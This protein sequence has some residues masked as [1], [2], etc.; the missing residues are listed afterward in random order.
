MKVAYSLV[1]YD[2]R[3]DF[4]VRFHTLADSVVPTAMEI[5]ALSP[6]MAAFYRDWPLTD[7]MMHRMEPLAGI[8]LDTEHLSWFLEPNAPLRGREAAAAE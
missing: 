2:K 5:A 1:G 6:E 8:A 3:T 7:E 4:A